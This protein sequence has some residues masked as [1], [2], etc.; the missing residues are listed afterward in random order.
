MGQPTIVTVVTYMDKAIDNQSWSLFYHL[1]HR[2]GVM[3]FM[4]LNAL[5]ALTLSINTACFRA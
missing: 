5:I 3:W 1:C 4:S 2:H